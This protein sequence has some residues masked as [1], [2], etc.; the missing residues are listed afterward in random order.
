ML[1]VYVCILFTMVYACLTTSLEGL[2]DAGN[3]NKFMFTWCGKHGLNSE[4]PELESQF[5]LQT[6]GMTLSPSALVSSYMK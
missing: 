4:I 1:R 5:C 3:M 6:C 2:R